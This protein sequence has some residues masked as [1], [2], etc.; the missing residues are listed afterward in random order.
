[1]H[2][3]TQLDPEQSNL[4]LTHV[5]DTAVRAVRKSISAPAQPA[6]EVCNVL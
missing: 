1:M 3:L 6:F 2:R 4:S 5:L